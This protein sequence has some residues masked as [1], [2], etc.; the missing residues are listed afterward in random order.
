MMNSYSSEEMRA[1]GPR[2]RGEADVGKHLGD[3][4]SGCA[5]LW[6]A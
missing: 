4:I 6:S 5:D 3:K 1:G 2:T